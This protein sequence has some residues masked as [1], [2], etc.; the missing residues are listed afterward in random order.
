[1]VVLSEKPGYYSASEM[2]QA[3]LEE[4]AWDAESQADAEAEEAAQSMQDEFIGYVSDFDIYQLG[5][6]LDYL[7]NRIFRKGTVHP[8]WVMKYS[9]NLVDFLKFFEHWNKTMEESKNGASA[10]KEAR[11]EVEK[12]YSENRRREETKADRIWALGSSLIVAVLSALVG[13]LLGRI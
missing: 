6:F 13:Y 9:I 11:S 10:T 3:Q 8:F 5:S 7:V 2:R 4:D 12:F 1:M